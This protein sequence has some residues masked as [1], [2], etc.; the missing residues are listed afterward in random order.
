MKNPDP[1]VYR[2]PDVAAAAIAGLRAFWSSAPAVD[3]MALVVDLS[4]LAEDPRAGEFS[5]ALDALILKDLG[6]K[7]DPQLVLAYGEK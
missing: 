6:K 1:P 7:Y 4:R 3:K 2:G 5:R